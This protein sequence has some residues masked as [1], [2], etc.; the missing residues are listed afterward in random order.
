MTKRSFTNLFNQYSDSIFRFAYWKVS[1]SDQAMDIVS[2][3]FI[4]AWENQEAFD[5]KHPQAWLFAIARNT[6][7]DAYRRKTPL[8]LDEIAEPTV[9]DH[10]EEKLD[11]QIA[12]EELLEALSSLRDDYREIVHWRFI[13]KRPVREIAERMG[14]SEE[15]IRIMQYR[16]LKKLRNWYEQKR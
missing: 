2:T 15:N 9:E 10:T 13:E 16:A 14:L 3:V 12:K 11:A 1:D 5:G 7:I 4:K 8:R 6:I